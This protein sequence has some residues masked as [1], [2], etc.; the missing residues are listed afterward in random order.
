MYDKRVLGIT[1]PADGDIV[2]SEST[3]DISKGLPL[4]SYFLSSALKCTWRGVSTKKKI[5][6]M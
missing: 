1:L 4:T 6:N 5:G 2:H 3:A